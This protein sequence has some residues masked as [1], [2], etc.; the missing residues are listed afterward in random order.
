[1]FSQSLSSISSNKCSYINGKY[2]YKPSSKMY[3]I[4]K[5]VQITYIFR[6][7][8]PSVLERSTQKV[9][10]RVLT[11]NIILIIT[12]Q[13]KIDSSS[14]HHLL[15]FSFCIPT[16]RAVATRGCHSTQILSGKTHAANSSIQLAKLG[17]E[18]LEKF[19][20]QFKISSQGN[21]LFQIIYSNWKNYRISCDR[22]CA[23]LSH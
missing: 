10:I 22:N 8:R 1:M 21:Y 2:E 14:V 9:H 13:W 17:S 5:L 15:T 11:S 19:L 16:F 23:L 20:N 3:C 12:L 6:F 7:L 18:N 4:R